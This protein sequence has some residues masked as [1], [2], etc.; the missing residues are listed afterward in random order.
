MIELIKEQRQRYP[1]LCEIIRF[2]IVGGVATIIDMF[3]MAC[4]IYFPNKDVFTDGFIS[5]FGGSDNISSLL[6]VVA[7]AIGFVVGL[8]FNYIFSIIYVYDGENKTAKTKKG[9]LVFAVLSA[10]GLAIQSIGMFIGY[11]L[12]GFNEWVVKIVLVLIVLVF[13]YI[14]RKI[15]LFNKSNTD[16][17]TCKD[18]VE[19]TQ[20][21]SKVIAKEV[22]TKRSLILNIIFV[23]S[24]VALCL[25]MYNPKSISYEGQIK[26][27]YIFLTAV[28][29]GGYL[30]V[31]NKNLLEK[32][33]LKGNI[34]KI[35][36]ATIYTLGITSSFLECSVSGLKKK[37]V[38]AFVSMFAIFCYSYLLITFAVKFFKYFWDNLS[39][40]NKRLFVIL[41]IGGIVFNTSV[42]MITNL[43]SNPGKG[44]DFFVS[45]DTGELLNLK[46]YENQLN[47]ENDFRHFLM[48]LC[49]LPF[50][51]I[52]SMLAKMFNFIPAID[53]LL[54]SYVQVV[55]IAYC[56]L[57]L[58][59]MLKIENKTL[60]VLF[61][62]LFAVMSGTYLNML[63]TEK[64]VF[65]LFYIIAT[66]SMSL[67]HSSWKWVFYI[68][69]IGIFTTNVFLLPIVI[70]ADKKPIK[71]WFAELV[72]AVIVF[73]CILLLSGQFN[74]VL[75]A[76][77]S[78]ESLKRFS[79][80]DKDVSTM[81]TITQAMIFI[82]ST[83]LS[84]LITK[85]DTVKLYTPGYNVM[86]YLGI[87]LLIINIISFIMNYKNKYARICFYWQLFMLVLLIGIGWG[88]ILN[89]MFIYSA[90]FAWST[91]SLVYMLINKI[92]KSVK[93]K[94]IILCCILGCVFI[95]NSIEFIKLLVYA[96]DMF[97]SVFL[98]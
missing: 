3:V 72:V 32:I 54:L 45:F 56:I 13:N 8:I 59:S 40:F 43:F 47:G 68:G 14:T 21:S 60:I 50:A 69:S 51:V 91:I 46:F 33:K 39:N 25:L 6:M 76:K 7:T 86:F 89:E 42:F 93:Y 94:V 15:F 28:I 9:F 71:D 73:I 77:Q 11:S 95:Y 30:F 66:V 24:S 84:P 88:A 44:Y 48:A 35:I 87:I 64:F 19:N 23:I 12:I 4:I 27:I 79:T 52:P 53:G 5:V 38:L 81:N 98:R 37:I 78:W 74:L 92:F 62:V 82:S 83:I 1:K 65:G 29:T 90:L 80:V 10:I 96:K 70:W 17:V 61:T 36:F 22:M 58:I 18:S 57:A 34:V 85:T 31:F 41:I 75:N 63:T 55:I 67:N 20:S 2:L 26:Y 16:D 49:I 97:P